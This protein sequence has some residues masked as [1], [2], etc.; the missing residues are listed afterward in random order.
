MSIIKV[1]RSVYHQSDLDAF[2]RVAENYPVTTPEFNPAT[3]L[4]VTAFIECASVYH[5]VRFGWSALKYRFSNDWRWKKRYVIAANF[6]TDVLQRHMG[7]SDEELKDYYTRNK[8]EFKTSQ[9][10]DSAG[11]LCTTTVVIPFDVDLKR[12]IAERM[13]LSEY[14]P[15]STFLATTRVPLGDENAVKGHWIKYVRYEGYQR[16]YLEKYFR[17]KFGVPYPESFEKIIGKGSVLSDKDTA[18]LISWMS[19]KR[20]KMLRTSSTA[21]NNGI[22]LLMRWYLFSDEARKTGYA[23]KKEIKE[24]VRW[25]WR[26]ELAQ[27][28]IASDITQRVSNESYIDSAMA[29]HSYWDISGDPGRVIDSSTMNNHFKQLIEQRAREYLNAEFGTLRRGVNVAFLESKWD[30]GKGGDPAQ[31]LRQ[32]DSLRIADD[33]SAAQ[34]AYRVIADNFALVPEGKKALVALA[35]LLTDRRQYAE[36][37]RQYRKASILHDDA[38][39]RCHCM[40]M[41]GFIYDEYLKRPEMAEANLKWVL[42]NAP[43]CE[44]ADEA[45]FIMLHL[46][47]PVISSEELQEEAVRQGRGAAGDAAG[48]SVDAE[49][50]DTAMINQGE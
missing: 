40:F 14:L 33:K 44:Y 5:K 26:Y 47:E 38:E 19:E 48:I 21:L 9:V 49:L 27:R 45:E 22:K 1:G 36:A 8:E 31:L 41:I 20:K 2:T 34:E 29:L 10:Q 6:V 12:Q 50:L 16:I 15:D 37:I 24:T 43:D 4:S 35:K 7:Y 32:A 42:K 39:L 3:R 11:T 18:T 25:L 13:F 23:S 46:S 30:D 17:K 28:Y